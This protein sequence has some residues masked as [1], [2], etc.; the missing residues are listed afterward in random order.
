[1]I[2]RKHFKTMLIVMYVMLVTL[3]TIFFSGLAFEDQEC[4]FF[5]KYFS[6]YPRFIFLA[7]LFF[8]GLIFSK[9]LNINKEKNFL[10]TFIVP[11]SLFFIHI[12]FFNNKL[13]NFISSNTLVITKAIVKHKTEGQRNHSITILYNIN[14]SL[15]K[16]IMPLDLSK[17]KKLELGDTI[18]LKYVKNCTSVIELY[19]SFPSKKELEK[20]SNDRYYK[21]GRFL[22]EL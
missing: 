11:I 3:L 22:D 19:K 14:K 6:T 4:I 12:Y 18:L 17:V 15:N 2:N 16:T 13:Q 1:M 5:E 21:N 9:F 8:I 10:F 20:F 7:V